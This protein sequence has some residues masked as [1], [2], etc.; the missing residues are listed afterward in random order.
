MQLAREQFQTSKAP[1]SACREL[2]WALLMS[3]EFALNH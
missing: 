3:S 2:A 1:Q